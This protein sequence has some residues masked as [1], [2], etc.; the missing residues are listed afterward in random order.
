MFENSIYLD[1]R[2]KGHDLFLLSIVSLSLEQLISCGHM[3]MLV[4]A[5][6]ALRAPEVQDRYDRTKSP[7]VCAYRLHVDEQRTSRPP[8]TT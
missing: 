8:T 7:G 6:F 3:H 4:T 5:P 1:T 2:L